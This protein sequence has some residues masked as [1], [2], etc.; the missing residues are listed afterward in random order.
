MNLKKSG[1]TA[2]ANYSRIEE[3]I[4]NEA[5]LIRQEIEIIDPEIIVGCFA[6]KKWW[7]IFLPDVQLNTKTID[8]VS[9]G[10]WRNIRIINYFHPSYR[11]SSAMSY[12]F[13][14][15]IFN[16]MDR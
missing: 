3:C 11:G 12:A 7:K 2:Y 15:Y 5:H 16:E 6:F 13:L 10:K 8:G 14:R 1:G 4:Q 9:V